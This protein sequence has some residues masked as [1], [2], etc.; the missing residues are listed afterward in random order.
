MTIGLSRFLGIMAAMM[1]TFPSRHKRSKHYS[2]PRKPGVKRLTIARGPGSISAKEEVLRL[3]QNE[4][5]AEARAY[6]EAHER[7][8]GEKLFPA[9]WWRVTDAQG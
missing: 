5:F 8:C 6:V 7:Q 3:V 9:A 4:Q 2:S 1:G